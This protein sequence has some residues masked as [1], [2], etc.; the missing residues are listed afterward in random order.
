MRGLSSRAHMAAERSDFGA[1]LRSVRLAAGLTQDELAERAGLSVRGIQD[2]ER[3]ARRSP[4]PETLRRLRAALSEHSD[5]TPTGAS[6]VDE[7]LRSDRLRQHTLAPS[8]T[9]PVSGRFPVAHTSFV[10]R[11]A[12]LVELAELLGVSRLLTLV[13]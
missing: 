5:A 10:G 13:G 12:Q 4:H 3:G 9:S 11:D 2:L 8:P 7:A 6:A 1:A